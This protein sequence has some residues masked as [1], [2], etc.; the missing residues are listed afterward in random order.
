MDIKLPRNTTDNLQTKAQA[1]STL[2]GTKV[3]HPADALD[4]VGMTTDVDSKIE[5]G[6][7]YWR[8]QEEHNLEL[9]QKRKDINIVEK[10]EQ[11]NQFNTNIAETKARKDAIKQEQGK[12]KRGRIY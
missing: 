4:M 12:E 11:K 7:E 2:N 8:E 6:K 9:E 3:L 1:F 5:K 10:Q